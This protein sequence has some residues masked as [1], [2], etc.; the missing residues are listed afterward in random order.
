MI[1]ERT[2]SNR[3]GETRTI[4][5]CKPYVVS[6]IV[7]PGSLVVNNW[8]ESRDPSMGGT[9][10]LQIGMDNIDIALNLQSIATEAKRSPDSAAKIQRALEAIAPDLSVLALLANG[11]PFQNNGS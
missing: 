10:S 8:V 6:K 3:R 9:Y 7:S 1:I 4:V 2:P 11:L 5:D